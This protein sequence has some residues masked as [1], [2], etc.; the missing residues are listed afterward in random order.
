MVEG[1]GKDE[2]PAEDFFAQIA[3]FSRFADVPLAEHYQPAPDDWDVVVTDVRG[4]TKAIEAGRYKDVNALGVAA[5]VC[6]RNA[7]P[8]VDIPFV[9][10]G[11]GAT[12]LVPHA[13]AEAVAAA[14]R[15]LVTMAQE[16]FALEMRAGVVPVRELRADGFT[17]LV[18]RFAASEHT[19]LAMFAGD[20]FTEAERRIKDE[21]SAAR[22]AVPEGGAVADF[23]GFE[24]R[25]QP[26]PAKNGLAMSLLVQAT[27]DG[28]D[29]AADVYQRVI[30]LIESTVD[31]EGRPVGV[32]RLVLRGLLGDYEQEARVTSG[33]PVGL[34]HWWRATRAR[35]FTGIGRLLMAAGRRASDFDG[36]SYRREVVSNTDFRKFDDTLRMVVD[37]SEAQRDHIEAKLGDEERA[38]RI[39]FGTHV[40]PATLMTC[41]IRGYAGDHVHFVD[42]ADGGYALAAKA[43]KRKLAAHRSSR[44]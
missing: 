43:L 25:W 37:V 9:F 2:S 36:A 33:R 42:G 41:M 35:V 11:D 34:G 13:R 14:L 1:R 20:G 6:L 29:A 7:L 10:G 31:D 4:S 16:A 21:K 23:E 28:R 18:A 12:L 40:A 44:L 19:R 15:G 30:E 32:D 8:D 17:V 22:Y 38:G 24:C 3:P 5:I 27:V 26:I 39:V